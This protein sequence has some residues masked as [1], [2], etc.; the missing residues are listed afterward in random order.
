[1]REKF[2]GAILAKGFMISHSP[3]PDHPGVYF[4]YD[5]GG[6]ILYIG[7]AVSLKKRVGSYFIKTHNKRLT[8]LVRQ[9]ARVEYKETPT[10]VEALILEANE[11]NKRQPKF[12]ILL[13]D[14][15]SFLYLVITRERFPKPILVRQHDLKKRNAAR[16]LARFGPYTNG[17]SLKTALDLA[18]RSIPW[19]TCESPSA[20]GKVKACFSRH[21]LLCPGVCTG[22]ISERDYRRVIQHLIHF[23]EGKKAIVVRALE[24]EMAKASKRLE[25]E[26]AGELKRRLFALQHI[27]DV[28]LISR[29]EKRDEAAAFRIEG[30]DVSNISGTSAVG[31]MVV[32]HEGRLIKNAYR[33]FRIKTVKG[34]NDVAMMEELTRRRLNHREWPLPDLMVV[35]GGQPQVNRVAAVLSEFDLKIPIIGLAKGSDRKQDR[36]IF[37]RGCDSRIRRLF[38]TDKKILQYT[39]D[40][41][42]RFAVSYHRKLRSRRMTPVLKKID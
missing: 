22:E 29:E 40:E 17:R 3:L 26:R 34:S 7:K 11:I 20:V 36:L 4:F 32:F 42:H 2:Y 39:R 37:S 13:K 30:Y 21:L 12:N 1:M 41:A 38:E 24:R 18:R 14:D 5:A 6:K 16:D 28:A 9:I 35:D 10:V 23:F 8:E 15:K 33:R 25:F 31:A 27:Q 19:S